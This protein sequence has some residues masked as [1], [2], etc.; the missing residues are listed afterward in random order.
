MSEKNSTNADNF[1]QRFVK[2]QSACQTL[3]DSIKTIYDNALSNEDL[4]RLASGSDEIEK[5]IA[6]SPAVLIS[7]SVNDAKSSLDIYNLFDYYKFDS[8]IFDKQRLFSAPEIL[9]GEL[10]D[11]IFHHKELIVSERVK[12]NELLVEVGKSWLDALL[13]DILYKKFPF[14]TT[15]ALLQIKKEI[16]NESN[17]SVLI[18]QITLFENFEKEILN[19]PI[20]SGLDETTQT[21]IKCDCFK[22]YIGALI[23]DNNNVTANDVTVWLRALFEPMIH[24]LEYNNLNGLYAG[25]PKEQLIHFVENN[26][27]GLELRFDT[28]VKTA[29]SIICNIYL[30]NKIIAMGD[31]SDDETAKQNAAASILADDTIVSKYSNYVFTFDET[32]NYVPDKLENA[33]ENNRETEIEN[34]HEPETTHD[35][36]LNE[37]STNQSTTNTAQK[38]EPGENV[39][40]TTEEMKELPLNTTSSKTNK[41]TLYREIGMYNCYPQYITIQLGLNDFYSSCH[42]LNKP[43]S[44]LGEGRGSNKKTAEQIAATSVLE[45]KSYKTFF[46][47][48]RGDAG[49]IKSDA[50]DSIHLLTDDEDDHFTEKNKSDPNSI[51]NSKLFKPSYYL[52]LELHT[53]CDKMAMTELYA[54]LGK[55]GFQPEYQTQAIDINDFYSFCLVKNTSVIIGEGRGTSKKMS[56]QIAATCALGGD[57]LKEFVTE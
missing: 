43:N 32:S 48:E 35:T 21:R 13:S 18:S 1:Q 11:L 30:G 49:D 45:S 10:K 50:D 22:S 15:S 37:K 36:M 40:R 14:T 38:K 54:E 52:D 2:L 57:A 44:F 55:Y 24:K 51:E 53:T 12:D 46:N 6:T 28:T 8:D 4:N 47:N 7:T 25:N 9:E 17:L 16:L 29:E 31:G 27:F 33:V 34:E 39:Q 26:K 56:Q 41:A 42:I 19:D 3:K 23:I 5:M 20:N